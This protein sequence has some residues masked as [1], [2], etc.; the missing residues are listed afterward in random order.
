[1]FRNTLSLLKY[2]FKAFESKYS[3]WEGFLCDGVFFIF[4][5][6]TGS[7]R[8][9]LRILDPKSPENAENIF[10]FPKMTAEKKV[11]SILSFDQILCFLTSRPFLRVLVGNN[12]VCTQGKGT[13]AQQEL[14]NEIL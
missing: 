13:R 1:M 6:H 14:S 2:F 12:R 8:F 7:Q 5:C 3:I 10:S 4:C 9:L 11:M